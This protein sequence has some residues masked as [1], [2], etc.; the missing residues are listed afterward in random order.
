MAKIIMEPT[1]EKWWEE[2]V[3]RG[4]AIPLGM[5]QGPKSPN[6]SDEK[7]LV[8]DSQPDQDLINFQNQSGRSS[9]NR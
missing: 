1:N 7:T 3:G 8:K 2:N 9:E 5:K 6:S 4:G